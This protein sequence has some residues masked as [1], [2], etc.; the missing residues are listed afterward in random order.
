MAKSNR[1]RKRD[2]AV[3]QA[4][5]ARKAAASQR[6]LITEAAM[7]LA[8]ERIHRINDP[9]TPVAEVA[10]LLLGHYAG[11]PVMPGITELLMDKGASP[12]RLAAVSDALRTAEVADAAERA[13]AAKMPDGLDGPSSPDG[14]GTP[15]TPAATGSSHGGQASLTYLTFAAGAA[16]A[17]GDTAG[18]R[19]LLDEAMAAAA[20]DPELQ[21]RLTAHLLAYGRAADAVESLEARLRESPEDDLAAEQYAM[22]IEDIFARLSGEPP[23]G[24]CPCGAGTSWQDCCGPRERTALDRFADRSGLRALQD[25]TASYL[26]RSGYAEAV[27][28]FVTDWTSA[29]DADSWDDPERE[30][31][32]A[33][34]TELAWTTAGASG[35]AEAEASDPS[36]RTGDGSA[37]HN[38]SADDDSADDDDDNLLRA[39]AADPSTP[40]ALAARARAWRDHVHYG[41]WQISDPVPSP[42]RWCTEIATGIVRYVAFGPEPAGL[43]PRWS[44]LLGAVVPVD[45]VWRAAGPALQLSP[46]E[47]DA[48]AETVHSA[49]EVIIRELAG[50]PTKRAASRMRQP[51]PF[52]RA[53]PHGVLVHYHEEEGPGMARLTSMVTASLLPRIAAE[54]HENRTT[55]PAMTNT[56][57]DPMCLIKARI[58]VRDGEVL[59]ERLAGHRDFSA[60]EDDPAALVWYGREVPVGQRDALLAEAVAQLRAQGHS[61]TDIELPAGP[62]RW[63]RGQL[64]VEGDELAVEVNSRERL[65]ALLG[66]LREAGAS[67]EVSDQSLID[68]RQDL[69]WPAGSRAR[70]GGSAEPQDGWEKQWLDERVPALRGRTPRQAAQAKERVLLEALLRQ[71]EYEADLLAANGQ[72]GVD[73]EWLRRELG[74]DVEEFP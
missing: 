64:R 36:V 69:A 32:L 73:T 65:A 48:A 30:A 39:F 38:D 55:S 8:V 9:A 74:M 35:T 70:P 34:V 15:E 50:K 22:A 14:T 7:R 24:P 53:E 23:A 31:F 54:L 16:Y 66:I 67:P 72:T 28:D 59:A 63:V 61:G 49:A 29:V 68:P 60:D 10:A 12:P 2:R 42:G 5:A 47:G 71:F 37:G 26:P 56:D 1:R 57:G 20:E 13:D 19:R 25:A 44:V 4:A 11:A 41:L 45:G 52:G 58:A 62:Q 27:A 43:A 40:P 46:T 51:V 21:V 33:L 17:A 6:Q 3:R 18:A